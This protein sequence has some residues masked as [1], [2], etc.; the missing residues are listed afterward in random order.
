MTGRQT[1]LS[2]ISDGVELTI[3]DRSSYLGNCLT[4]DGSTIEEAYADLSPSWYSTEVERSRILC[5]SGL[6]SV[7]WWRGSEFAYRR[8][9]LLGGFR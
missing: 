5:H 1:D 7:V 3:L 6:I 2:L 9:L 8:R 4:E